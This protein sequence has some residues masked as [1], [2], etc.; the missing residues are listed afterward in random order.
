MSFRERLDRVLKESSAKSR[1]VTLTPKQVGPSDTAISILV[2]SILDIS[3]SDLVIVIDESESLRVIASNPSA[4]SL[5]FKFAKLVSELASFLSNRRICNAKLIR[6][7]S[8]GG[9]RNA[10]TPK[11]L[12]ETLRAPF[13]GNTRKSEKTAY[14][15]KSIIARMAITGH[16]VIISDFRSHMWRR[17]LNALVGVDP[18][19]T[20]VHLVDVIDC[21]FVLSPADQ[22][23]L[24]TLPDPTP[25]RT[26][27]IDSVIPPSDIHA[28][29]TAFADVNDVNV[30][31]I[32]IQDD[33]ME[34]LMLA[35]ERAIADV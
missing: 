1:S 7:G 6:L 20:L 26:P 33:S 8:C 11:R 16:I 3:T 18:R 28:Y 15:L 27:L 30:L 4:A 14:L 22:L 9:T 12:T 19:V 34:E 31:G 13:C 17:S 5:K 23:E 29:L 10:L 25:W 24:A 32:V 21:D 2:D 35:F